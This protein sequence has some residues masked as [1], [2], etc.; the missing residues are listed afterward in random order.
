MTSKLG[1]P[2]FEPTE[3]DI[4]TV[5]MMAAYGIPQAQI[6]AVVGVSV[7]T[8]AK[9][10]QEVLAKSAIEANARVAGALFRMATTDHP[11]AVT[12]AIFWLKC[13]AGWTEGDPDAMGKKARAAE[14]A[15]TAGAGTEWG[16]DL[17][18]SMN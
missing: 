3:R 13:R 16:D 2:S 17:R 10:F 15:K 1:R 7:P 8:L 4:R 6:A 9:H 11:K 18:S 5:Q 12:A 14:A